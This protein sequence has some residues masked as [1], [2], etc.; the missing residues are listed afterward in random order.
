MKQD[1]AGREIS[2]NWSLHFWDSLMAV[3]SVQEEYSVMRPSLLWVITQYLF[4]DVYRH[5]GTG[6]RFHVQGSTSARRILL[7]LFDP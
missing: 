2:C 4:I 7:G 3:Y 1:K 5:F 6:C